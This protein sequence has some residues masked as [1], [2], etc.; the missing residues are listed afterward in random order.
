LADASLPA[1][2]LPQNQLV[3]LHAAV[4]DNSQAEVSLLTATL[5]TRPGLNVTDKTYLISALT[6]A[7]LPQF[8][9]PIAADIY[10]EGLDAAL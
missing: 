7:G 2:T 9:G 5:L 4:R 8:A 10:F 1:L 3:L 6:Q